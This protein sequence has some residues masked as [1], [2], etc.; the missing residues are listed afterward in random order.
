MSS[1][2]WRSASPRFDG[3]LKRLGAVLL[4]KTKYKF[5]QASHRGGVGAGGLLFLFSPLLHFPFS[6]F[7]L[8]FF[9][10]T[11]LGG[12]CP[13]KLPYWARTKRHHV[14]SGD[15]RQSNRKIIMSLDKELVWH[16]NIFC[17]R[18]KL[19]TLI[20][21]WHNHNILTTVAQR[22]SVPGWLWI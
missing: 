19:A 16:S 11:L 14:E 1:Y 15:R 2:M 17:E 3:S 6:L 7:S 8:F 22:D 10:T 18:F 21:V 4:V 12:T 9:F 20:S 13:L 5:Y